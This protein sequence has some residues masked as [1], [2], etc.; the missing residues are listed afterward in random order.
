MQSTIVTGT[1]HARR[2]GRECLC[3]CRDAIGRTGAIVQDSD[4]PKL[5][6]LGLLV[7]EFPACENRGVSW[8]AIQVAYSYAEL[9][10]TAP[11]PEPE[12][13]ETVR[14]FEPAPAQVPGQL[15][16]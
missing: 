8:R 9:G 4:T 6:T 1:R 11:R 5:A 16:L 13:H 3:G 14:L 12:R 15:A 7:A 2:D 10:L